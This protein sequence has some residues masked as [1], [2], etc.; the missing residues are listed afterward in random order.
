MAAKQLE[1]IRDAEEARVARWFR[2]GA[3][4]LVYFDRKQRAIPISEAQHERWRAE[5]V[6]RV[7]RYVAD[8]ERCL[9]EVVILAVCVVVAAFFLKSAL[10]P[11]IPMFKSMQ[12][13]LFAIPACFLPLMYEVSFRRDQSALRGRIEERLILRTPLPE[14]VA[15][16][17]RRYNVFTVGQGVTAG[18]AV[19]IAALALYRD[20]PGYGTLAML[21]LLVLSW[22]FSWAAQRVDAVHRRRLW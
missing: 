15:T 19:L 10:A 21:A 12:P 13:T 17:S 14:D 2:D 4:G 3:H 9:K 11:V 18:G 6:K 7:D 20:D 5:A 16:R 22:L 1:R 8:L